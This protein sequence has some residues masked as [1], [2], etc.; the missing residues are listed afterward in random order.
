MTLAS[1]PMYDLPVVRAATDAWWQGLAEILRDQGISEVPAQ[2]TRGDLAEDWRRS[3]LLGQR[4]GYELVRHREDLTLVATPVYAAAHCEGP[5]YRSAFVV[6]AS[7]P[8]ES[9][10]DLRS[11]VCVINGR[12]SHSGNTALRHALAPLAEG[13]AFFSEVL[14]SGAHAT[15]LAWIREGRADI[16]AVD[17]VTFGLV[18]KHEPAAV[19]GLRVLATSAPAPGL[20]Y[21]TRGAAEPELLARLRAGLE[22]AAKEPALAAAR[23]ALLIS[24][25]EVLPETA[26]DRIREM[27][28]AADG[29]GYPEVA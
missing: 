28:A 15:S 4:C 6:S 29:L 5:D 17:C 24:G 19:E 25:F 16:T 2:L 10:A 7:S 22:L 8:A 9:L 27:E 23:E 12:A 14:E 21:V 13:Q 18:K 3:L 1:F 26:Y 20:P 11:G